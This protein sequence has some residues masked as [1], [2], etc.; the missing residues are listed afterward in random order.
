MDETFSMSTS[1]NEQK[2]KGRGVEEEEFKQRGPL[3]KNI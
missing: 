1:N 2:K 3:V